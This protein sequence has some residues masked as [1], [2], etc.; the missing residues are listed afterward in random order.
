MKARY[1][2]IPHAD[3]KSGNISTWTK[4]QRSERADLGPIL[5]NFLRTSAELFMFRLS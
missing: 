5:R 2:S 4:E 1:P 3:R